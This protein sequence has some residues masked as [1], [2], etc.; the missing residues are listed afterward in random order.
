MD[1][2]PQLPRPSWFRRN[3]KWVVPVG[4]L[5]PVLACVGLGALIVSLVF[6][7]IKSS[8]PYRDALSAAKTNTEVR[9]LLGDPIEAGFLVSGNIQ[10]SNS[11]GSADLSIPISG[12]KGSATIYVTG[13]KTAGVWTYSVLKVTPSTVGTTIDLHAGLEK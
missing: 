5:V 2:P 7:L 13:T 1:Q 11:N 12:A 10:T 8:D 4:C 3:W 9:T 6:G